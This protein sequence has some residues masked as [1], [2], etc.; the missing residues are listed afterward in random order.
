[1]KQTIKMIQIISVTLM[2]ILAVQASAAT[3]ITTLR[4]GK[5]KA[6]WDQLK[7]MEICVSIDLENPKYPAIV[8]SVNINDSSSYFVN[9]NK[10]AATL[11]EKVAGCN[12]TH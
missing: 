1:M 10:D 3:E 6:L 12:P 9:P 5:G 11:D 8:K 4:E 7:N 2:T